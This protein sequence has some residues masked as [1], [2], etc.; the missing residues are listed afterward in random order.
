MKC[1]IR[2]INEYIWM[3]VVIVWRLDILEL[4]NVWR[5]R[6]GIGGGRVRW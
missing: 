3:R 6:D 1:L 5:E 4:G 2:D